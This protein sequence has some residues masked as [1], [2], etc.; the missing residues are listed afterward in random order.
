MAIIDASASAGL[1][2]LGRPSL[3]HTENLFVGVGEYRWKDQVG[4]ASNVNRTII[5]AQGS[6]FQY[7][8]NGN[9]VGGVVT[10]IEID[11]V[12]FSDTFIPDVV[13]TGISVPLAQLV[14][15]GDPNASLDMFVQTVFSGNDIFTGASGL[16]ALVG[17][18]YDID[19]GEARTGGN[20]TFNINSNSLV[21]VYGDA[22]EVFDGTLDG[23]NDLFNLSTSDA[24]TAMTAAGESFT[25]DNIINGGNDTIDASASA[26]G[27]DLSGESLFG[28]GG[29]INGGND[30]ITGSD[31][32]DDTISGEG[33]QILS[34]AI[35]GGDDLLFGMGGD[36]IIAGEAWQ[37][38]GGTVIGGDDLLEG[39]EG[40]D[41]LFGEVAI[42]T[43]GTVLSGGNDTLRG[44]NGNDTLNGGA[45]GDTL[46]G[47]DGLDIA[48]Y[49]DAMAKVRIDLLDLTKNQGDA[50]GDSYISIERFAGGSFNDTF[51]ADNTRNWMAGGDG[52]DELR[53]R[54]GRD[55]LLGDE[56]VDTLNGGKGRDRLEGGA[57]GDLLLGLG[58]RDNLRGGKG[59]DTL[60]GGAGD[61]TQTGGKGDDTFVFEDANGEDVIT[62]F[63]ALDDGEKIDLSAVTALNEIGDLTGPGGAASQQGMDVLID[64]GGGNSIRL[65]GVSLGDLDANDFIF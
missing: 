7:D 1:S 25:A 54:G 12:S 27:G 20:D 38:D 64:T 17:D 3:G 39:G 21:N 13:I 35:T 10:R 19:G 29:T 9:P 61:D 36:D 43:S 55:T 57:D 28:F 2:M 46:N 11:S 44:G 47:G 60:E 42:L 53:G 31:T 22:R 45:G 49:D 32:N 26:A 52:A 56:G 51:L 18:F 16:N 23:G 63:D 30:R 6:Q 62:D 58:G 59:N 33:S 48:T 41:A 40:N 4:A 5:S 8:G 14:V 50:L 37:F 65:Q 15:F 34:S 24:G